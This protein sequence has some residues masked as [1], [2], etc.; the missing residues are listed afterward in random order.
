MSEQCEHMYYP[1]GTPSSTFKATIE[2]TWNTYDSR[3]DESPAAQRARTGRACG[4]FVLENM[5]IELGTTAYIDLLST[6]GPVVI[7]VE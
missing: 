7:T 4:A 1:D 6:Y 2:D 3:L 5:P